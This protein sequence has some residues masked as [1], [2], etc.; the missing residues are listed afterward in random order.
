[1]GGGH[2][3]GGS[4]RCVWRTRQVIAGAR[5]AFFAVQ[6]VKINFYTTPFLAAT[7]T[8]LNFQELLI[9]VSNQDLKSV[10]GLLCGLTFFLYLHLNFIGLTLGYD[11]GLFRFLFSVLNVTIGY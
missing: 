8:G 1:M 7:F 4:G 6:Q 3:G 11:H 9:V 2:G 10:L 5:V